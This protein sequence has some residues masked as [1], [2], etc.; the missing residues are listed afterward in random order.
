MSHKTLKF[1]EVKLSVDTIH[2]IITVGPDFSVPKQIRTPVRNRI[3]APHQSHTKPSLVVVKAQFFQCIL[4]VSTRLKHDFKLILKSA[5]CVVHGGEFK[6]FFC[7][8]KKWLY[9]EIRVL[10]NKPAILE[11]TPF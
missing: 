8:L 11:L 5:R 6:I 4:H 1:L 3:E 9:G 2:F 10:F 7:D